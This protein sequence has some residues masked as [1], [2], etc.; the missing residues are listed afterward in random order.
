[1]D[2]YEAFNRGRTAGE[3]RKRQSAIS[4]YFQGPR[5]AIPMR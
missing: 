1:M 3:E 5:A 4:Q 2:L